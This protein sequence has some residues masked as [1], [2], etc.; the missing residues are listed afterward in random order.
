MYK[1]DADSKSRD[2]TL[3]TLIEAMLN[4]P[5]DEAFDLVR[6]LRSC[7]SLDVVAERIAAKEHD[8]DFDGDF[9]ATGQSDGGST[10]EPTFEKHFY[11]KM[12]DLRLNEGTV[13]YIGGTSHLI[14]SIACSIRSGR[15]S[16]VHFDALKIG[17]QSH[18]RRKPGSAGR[19]AV[20]HAPAPG[21]C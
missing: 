13:R 2:T 3:H 14:P 7:D 10:L 21:K 8:S 1:T 9:G 12:G 16:V 19:D 17:L 18:V 4:L 5:E 11:G 20:V 6:E 15:E